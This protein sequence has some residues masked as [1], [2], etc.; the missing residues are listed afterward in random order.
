[1]SLSH[2]FGRQLR[3]PAGWRGR[4]LGVL[5]RQLNS[6]CNRLAVEALA[7]GP[8]DTVLELGFGPGHALS[9][10][11]R[12]AP[13]GRVYGIERSAVMLK[14]AIARNRSA[15]REGRV[16]LQHGSFETLPF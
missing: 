11:A 3:E 10:L 15:V 16:V 2:A 12:R 1:M 13:H 6:Q 9:L 4:M 5:M 8:S 14:Q 7:V